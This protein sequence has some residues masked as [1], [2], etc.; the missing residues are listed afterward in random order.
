MLFK[1]SIF[2]TKL[3]TGQY[4]FRSR[5]SDVSVEYTTN[6]RA[7]VRKSP[8]EY[9]LPGGKTPGLGLSDRIVSNRWG[10]TATDT[11]CRARRIDYAAID[12]KPCDAMR[13][14]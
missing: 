8:H 4:F 5:N 10:G 9:K 3:S 6:E 11:N 13:T 14:L 1:T 2:S 12:I 7:V